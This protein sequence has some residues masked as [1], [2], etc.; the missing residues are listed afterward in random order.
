MSTQQLSSLLAGVVSDG[1]SGTPFDGEAASA[2]FLAEARK[3]DA[4]ARFDSAVPPSMRESDW[5]HAAM[6]PNRAQIDRRP[7]DSFTINPSAAYLKG[8]TK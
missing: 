8:L 2:H 5:G 3:R 7:R 1:F 4:I 6:A